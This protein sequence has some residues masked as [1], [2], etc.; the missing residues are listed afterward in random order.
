MRLY[1]RRKTSSIR[2]NA[3]RRDALRQRRPRTLEML[4]GRVLLAA[5][6]GAAIAPWH[7]QYN[8]RDVNH[9]FRIS[10][11][12]AL[13]VINDL[14]LHGARAL[15]SPGGVSPFA[16]TATDATASTQT[17][18]SVDVNGDNRVSPS[19]A[20][21]VINALLSTKLL[22]VDATFTNMAGDPISSVI[23]GTDF[24]MTV[25]VQDIRDPASATPGVFSASVNLNYDPTLVSIATQEPDPG[26]S[27]ALIAG[28][29]IDVSTP[30][31]IPGFLALSGFT[32][33]GNSP[34]DLWTIVVHASSPG[35][36]HFLSSFDTTP[37]N[38]TTLYP[39][40]LLGD[41]DIQFNDAA[42]TILGPA[43][44]LVA[45][46][47]QFEG[48][49]GQTPMVFTVSLSSA[50]SEV[51]TVEFNIEDDT[52]TT[53]GSDYVAT[54]GTLTFQPGVLTQLVTVLVNGD[55]S[56]ESDESF[57]LVLSNPSGGE[58]ADDLAIGTI[59]NDDIVPSLAVSN[60]FQPEGNAGNSDFVFTASLSTA[61]AQTIVV[62][63]TVDDG[64]ATTAN[65][66]YLDQSG[67]LTFAPGETSKTI[68]IS[69]VGDTTSEPDETF[70]VTATLISGPVSNASASGTGTI[71]NDEGLRVA[72]R[73][74]VADLAGNPLPGGATLNLNDDFTLQ[75]YVR[76]IQAVPHGIFQAAADALYDAN[77][78]QVT[79]EISYGPYFPNLP[80]PPGGS[81]ATPGL[82]DEVVA[83]AD[84]TPPQLPA[85]DPAGE[86]LFFSIPLRAI[87]SGL[88]SFVIEPADL[89]DHDVLVYT[90]DEPLSNSQLS[91]LGTSIPI[92][93]NVFNIASVEIPEGNAG[94]TNFLFQVERF[95]P[96]DAPATVVYSTDDFSATVA[97]GDY[98]AQSGTLTFAAGESSKTITIAVTG[99]TK[100]ELNE[101][102][103]V[104]LSDAQGADLG[105]ASANG[106]IAN[107]DGVVG[108]SVAPASGNEG[109]SL[110]FIVTLSAASGI[111]V[112]VPF[113]TVE[114]TSGNIATSNLDYQ[115][116]GNVL[117]FPAGT[118]ERTITVVTHSDDE[119]EP[120]ETFEVVL[121][122]PDNGFL[123]QGQAQGTI[124]DVPP[125]TILSVNNVTQAEGNSGSSNMLF[126]ASLSNATTLPVVYTYATADGSATTANGD[127]V[128][129]S[130]TLTFAPGQTSKVISI[131]VAGDTVIEPSETFTI[132][133]TRVS[134]P[135]DNASAQATGTIANDDGLPLLSIADVAVVPGNSGFT[136][137]V[138]A[139]TLSF[140]AAEPVTVSF[141]TLDFT[142]TANFDYLAQSGI[143]TFT[144][145]GSLTQ[146][147]IVPVIG[148]STPEENETFYVNLSSV[149]ANAQ[150][151]DAQAV[152]TIVR[153]GLTAAAA[154][155]AEGNSGT[156]QLV[157]AVNLSQSQVDTVTVHYNT[158]DGTATVANN[159]YE[160]TSGDLTFLPGQT[161]HSVT[162]NVVGDSAVEPNEIF[163]LNLSDAEGALLLASQATGT[164]LNDDGLVA[165]LRLQVADSLG[166]PIPGGTPLDLDQA[167]ILQVYVQDIQQEPQGVFQAFVDAVY[168]SNLVQ[169]TGPITFGPEFPTPQAG[170]VSTPGLL[171]EVGA[172]GDGSPPESPGTEQLFF[173]VPMKAIDVG[174]ANFTLNPADLGDHE[175]LV[176]FSDEAIPT[177]RVEYLDTAVNIGS[178]VFTVENLGTSEGNSGTKEFVFTVSR[179]LPEENEATVVYATED[180]TATAASGDYVPQSGTLTFAVGET[181]K[182][183]TITVNGDT[184]DEENETFFIRLSDPTNANVSQSPG[185]GTIVNDDGPVISSISDASGNEGQNLTFVVTLSAVSGKTVTVPFQTAAS[186]SGNIATAGLDYTTASGVVTFAPGVTQQTITVHSLNDLLAEPSETF[187]VVL[188]TPTN[189]TLD[190]AEAQGTIH[191]VPPS[192]LRGEVYVDLNGNGL[193]DDGEL[194]I[195]G[196]IVTAIL[197]EGGFS[198]STLTAADGT[199]SL[200]GLVPGTYT[201]AETH[202]GFYVDGRDTRFGVDS[203]TND[204]FTGVSLAPNADI[205]GYN[206]GEAGVRPEFVSLFINRRAFFATTVV[207]GT[208]GPQMST[209]GTVNPKNGDVWISFDG[210]WDGQRTIDALFD[211][212]LGTATM[213]LFNN[214]LQQ[215]ASS[216]P[217]AT[218]ASLI[219]NGIS[220]APYFLKISG[221]NT[222]VALSFSDAAPLV[223][224]LAEPSA[225]TTSTTTTSTTL[226]GGTLASSADSTPLAAPQAA[227]SDDDLVWSDE[228]DWIADSLLV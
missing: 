214:N 30:G 32:P 222:S 39:D 78:V 184:T 41:A 118:T 132:N 60:V 130:G 193:R 228:D 93:A 83:I 123:Q 5:D 122:T 178:N 12:D 163:F 10:P 62:S 63:Y 218:G 45:D 97:D 146:N 199:Y 51:V 91:F 160:S 74:Q 61:A 129:K 80:L 171:D 21:R 157:F 77:L 7:N 90:D 183:I 192:T 112:S 111:V 190:D 175:V 198:Q 13:L 213:T 104:N 82:I 177:N 180:G 179:F 3:R 34:L 23:V 35:T 72:L 24:K 69:V 186:S 207:G 11:M 188:G 174:L 144:P 158:V 166:N 226:G 121:G 173:S 133:L 208:S 161:S 138:F 79:G 57:H 100:F 26:P 159:D 56:P 151:F 29:Q 135:A 86:Y 31:Q 139:V 106:T 196:V 211:A 53:A 8:P 209:V 76:D 202:P 119:L 105:V 65:N 27:F 148:Q 116:T 221:T 204:R 164:I 6:S 170:D 219:Y 64:T 55:S 66:D 126:T 197:E 203:P 70:S 167:F 2:K 84:G 113:N 141:S 162:V 120:S 94:S 137:A 210:G 99:D 47:A 19:D 81:T 103:R 85:E 195:A 227:T 189:A 224:P 40:V 42:I 217:T 212:S 145:G 95:L 44:I 33:N 38:E 16:A 67:T 147:I 73:L 136:D 4:E 50:S 59:Q 140:A 168:D 46:Q 110:E 154:S 194:G 96:A 22:D 153:K 37:A 201:L 150:I 169:L 124:F 215:V 88:A 15:S 131:A 220:G 206:F 216:F 185:V 172:L 1:P 149:S 205:G 165:R 98:I 71:L 54:S 52:A 114:S 191:D 223:E 102:F 9:D 58:L 225:S 17:T 117:V 28:Q 48:D 36:A 181:Q 125:P 18:A 89:A 108:V 109:Q 20:L 14:R 75:A 101:I 155:V 68:T 176:Y 142:A 115:N 156:T 134:G 49:S 107:D 152:G 87:H 127:Y 43:S 128:A 200:L 143:L 182:F 187:R 92:G 25:V